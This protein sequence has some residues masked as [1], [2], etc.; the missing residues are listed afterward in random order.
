MQHLAIRVVHGMVLHPPRM[1]ENLDITCGALF[2]ERRVA[3]KSAGGG[4]RH[5]WTGSGSGE[6]RIRARKPRRASTQELDLDIE[7]A[8]DLQGSAVATGEPQA[9]LGGRCADERARSTDR[10]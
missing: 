6:P 10:Q 9:M 3:L 1:R 8:I 5:H 7:R 2:K 4:E